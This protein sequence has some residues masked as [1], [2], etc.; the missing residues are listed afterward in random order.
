[1]LSSTVG[2]IFSLIKLVIYNGE[3]RKVGRMNVLSIIFV[4]SLL[5]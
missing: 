4:K 5:N 1:M 2:Q 3:I